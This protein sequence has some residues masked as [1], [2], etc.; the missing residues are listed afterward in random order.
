MGAALKT[1]WRELLI[2][3]TL[4]GLFM[5]SASVFGVLLEHPA[6]GARAALPDA[7]LRRALM[8]V[9]M[10]LTAVALIYSPWGKRSG[11]HMNPA[12]TLT[13]WRLGKVTGKDAALYAAAQF[14]GGLA[15]MG[16][17]AFL[18]KERVADAAVHYV[19]TIPG[20]RGAPSAFFGELFISFALM[21]TVLASSTR[22]RLAPFTGIL[23][24][25]LIF[26][27]IS[28][29]APFSGTSM[30]P[31]R[32]L[33]SAVPARDFTGLWVYFL[34][35]PLGMLLAVE[36]RWGVGAAADAFCARLSP[37]GRA[38][39]PFCGRNP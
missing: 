16:V 38:L 9:A 27:F 32:T 33:A 12:V 13:F 3:G 35:P 26:V 19:V 6:S 5:V 8:G 37:H 29:E 22:P 24:A 28:F 10:G 18:L 36:A 17:A 23:C 2:E 1:R 14:L 21:A 20:P 31:A 7:N 25:V 11:A 34:A 15:G 39:C 30:N 4:L